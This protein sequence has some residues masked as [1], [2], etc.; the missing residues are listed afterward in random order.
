VDRYPC[1]CC[2]NFT[3]DEEPPGTWLICEVYWWEDDPVQ[4]ADPELRGGANR[5][6]PNEARSY[7]KTIGFSSPERRERRRLEDPSRLAEWTARTRTRPRPPRQ[8]L[9]SNARSWHVVCGGMDLC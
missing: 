8:R 6:S 3:L 2:G 4:F 7:F 9:S 5:V 1:L